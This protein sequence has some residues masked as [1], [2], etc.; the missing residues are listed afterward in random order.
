VDDPE[1]EAGAVLEV[2]LLAGRDGVEFGGGD[3]GTVVSDADDGPGLPACLLYTL[4]SLRDSGAPR[5]P[6]LA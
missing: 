5:M 3:A 6:L 1:A 2:G 4:P